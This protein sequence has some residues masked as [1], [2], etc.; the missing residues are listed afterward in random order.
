MRP[1]TRR[2]FIKAS[3]LA[4]ASAALAASGAMTNPG[5]D[6]TRKERGI[7]SRGEL[8]FRP[9]LVQTGRGPHLLE[10]AYAT[11]TEWDS[12]HSDIT[13]S[14]DG[15]RVSDTEGHDRFGINVRW[16][17]EG[18]GYIYITADNGGEFYQLPQGSRSVTLNL[19]YEL[20]KSRAARNRRRVSLHRQAGWQPSRELETF[21]ALSEGYLSDAAKC[22]NDGEKCGQ[23]A[24]K[25]LYYTMWAGEMAELEK[26]KFDI[27][28][29]GYRPGFF[30]GCDARGY[31][32]MDVELFLFRFTELFNY[33]T[34]THYLISGVFE[35]FEPEEGRTQYDLRDA[36]F[37]QLRNHGI[38]VEGRPLWWSYQTTTPD[39][40]RKKSYPEILK[41]LEKHVREM[42]AHYG[43]GMYAWEIVN[44]LH[45]WANECGLTPEQTI[46]LTRLACEVTRATNP[47][48]KRLINNCAPFAEYVQLGRWTEKPAK[49][50]QRT[51]YQFLKQLNE[52][53]VDYDI[54]G[55][56][57]YFPYRDLA[58]TIV[59]IEKFATLGKTIQLTEVGASSGPSEQSIKNGTLGFPT[60]PYA[61]H[62]HWDEELQAE[63][64][65]G[66]YTL[67][68]SKPYIEAVNWYDFVD[69]Y[70]WIKNGGLLRSP[71]GEKKAAFECL[72][73][74]QAQWKQLPRTQG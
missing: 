67:A 62:R 49:Y 9:Y 3:A 73:Q 42:V 65:E 15:V 37:K 46:E 61:W 24:Q 36:L 51:P 10:W 1:M 18:F 16:N 60:E 20:A 64:L 53:G 2:K 70:S 14:R 30:I 52:A 26:A 19:N 29:T 50:P 41:Y 17:V 6:T 56:Q 69:P 21:V 34:I 33:A 57:M 72:A 13:A 38:T 23:L 48:V 59:L 5:P 31:F 45:D 39:W 35:D 25:A 8:C 66:L 63:W 68:Y 44:E 27:S 12:F 74:L 4:G 11:D 40:L 7:P 43:D 54:A 22:Q 47:K 55:V 32:Q 28:R 71:K 58:D